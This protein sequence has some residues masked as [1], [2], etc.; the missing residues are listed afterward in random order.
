MNT[1]I[2][3]RDGMWIEWDVSIK[4][5]DGLILKADVFRPPKEGECH[6]DL[7][8]LRE[9]FAVSSWISECMAENG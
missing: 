8:P 3:E 9:G 4:M 5:D 1:Q 2:D 7:W 6:L